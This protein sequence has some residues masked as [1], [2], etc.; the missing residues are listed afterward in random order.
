MNDVT[1][2]FREYARLDLMRLDQGLTLVEHERWSALKRT[3][4]ERFGRT[5]RPPGGGD[6]RSAQRVETRLNCAYSAGEDRR[7]AVV[8]N[9]STGG[10]FIRTAWPLPVD[11]A[12]CLD[13]QLEE[14]GEEI[15]VHG[16]VVSINMDA[17]LDTA[18]RGMGV[19]FVRVDQRVLEQLS[20][21]YSN[22][23]SRDIDGLSPEKRAG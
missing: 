15:V 11:T 18:V 5:P 16:V 6:Q 2:M 19:R 13:I 14:T 22:E 9:L 21:L 20:A 4:D 10:V 8:S 1:T 3:L 12:L 7:E 23:L 17:R